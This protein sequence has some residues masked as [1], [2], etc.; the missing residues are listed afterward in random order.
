MMVVLLVATLMLSMLLCFV[1]LQLARRWQIIDLPNARSAHEK[2]IPRGGGIAIILTWNATLL[3]GYYWLGAGDMPLVMLVTASL[4]VAVAGF[5]DDVAAL[6]AFNRLLVYALVCAAV[7]TYLP[8]DSVWLWPLA[9]LYLLWLC[10]L[11]NFMDGI[12]GIAG[13]QTVFI[14]VAAA[15]LGSFTGAPLWQLVA[16]LGLAA[17]ACG[18]L[19]FNW[20]RAT[21]FMGDSGS[22]SLGL[23]V[24][25]LSLATDAGVGLPLVSWLI[26]LAAFATDTTYTLVR[27]AL[28]GE[29][30]MQAHNQHLYQR[31]SRH[32]HS[33]ERVLLALMLLNMLWLLP[34]A[35][36]AAYW[37][38]AG[39]AIVILAYL[40]LI[41]FMRKTVK[42]T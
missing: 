16:A 17:A 25:V 5:W 8:L 14:G 11:Y 31:L 12:D 3:A 27:R 38:R 40:P 1:Y 35:A 15:A 36:A 32:W 26:L 4:A 18:F 6:P 37:P 22:V 20:P 29:S 2:P 39:L 34:L 33:H 42:I 24:G 10:N 13:V 30:V 41:I 7:I 28:A 19:V 23:I 9:W 21:L